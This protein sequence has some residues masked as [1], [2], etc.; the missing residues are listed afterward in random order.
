MAVIEAE[1]GAHPYRGA[2]W[3]VVR[4][5]IHSTADF[6]FAGANAVRFGPG[7]VEA[8]LRALRGGRPVVADVNGVAAG[9]APQGTATGWYAAYP[10]GERPRGRSAGARRARRRP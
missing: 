7:S 4:R 1:I 3:L 2:E 6:D 10:S 5:I 9:R 8:G